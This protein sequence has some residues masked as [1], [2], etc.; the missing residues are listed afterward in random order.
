MRSWWVDNASTGAPTILVCTDDNGTLVGGIALEMDTVRIG[1]ARVARLR[2]VGQGP[3]APDHIDVLSA[4]GERTAVLRAVGTWL[5]TGDWVMDL[6]GLNAT[7]E[8]PWLL[9][10]PVIAREPAP[11]LTLGTSDPVAELPGRLRSTIKRSAKRLARS[12]FEVVRVTATTDQSERAGS[13]ATDAL[14][15][16][17][18]DPFETALDTLFELHA[19]RWEDESAWGH[20]SETLRRTLLAGLRCGE[21][22]IHELTNGTEVIASELELVC[23][24]RVAFYQAGRLTDHDYRGS[25]SVLKAAVL[26]WAISE[27]MAEFDLLRGDDGYKDDWSDS[28]RE[29]RRARR[30]FGPRGGPSAQVLNLW[31]RAAPSVADMTARITA[32]GSSDSSAP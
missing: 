11:F 7:C 14:G 12:G 1:P 19:S 6:D 32:R 29:V 15:A 4:E 24:R 22:V 3:L 23:G 27:S 25:G 13:D 28:S 9:G 17:R 8:L 5:R 20:T 30:G 18:T 16:M 26:R 10:A 21:A 2:V 31:Q